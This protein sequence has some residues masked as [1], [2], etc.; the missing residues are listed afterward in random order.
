MTDTVIVVGA[1]RGFGAAT[2]DALADAGRHVIAIARTRDELERRHQRPEVITVAGDGRDADLAARL[3][4]ERC[5]AAIVIGGGIAPYM[6]PLEEHTFDTLSQHWHHDVAIAFTWLQAILTNELAELR[7]VI[8]ISSGAGLFG[9]H[10]S[11]GYAGSKAATRF[12]TESAADSAR[13]RGLPIR[14]TTVNPK[15]TSGTEL[16]QVAVAGYARINGGDARSA[17]AEP[18][19]Y[20][21]EHAGRLIATLIVDPPAEHNARYLL[22]ETDLQPV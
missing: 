19:L 10:G 6:A 20:G 8:T 17:L 22:T 11:G 2:V 7:D 1:S 21:P 15:L 13:R 18:A 14:F 16:G 5:P 9:S 12:L 3:L 4:T